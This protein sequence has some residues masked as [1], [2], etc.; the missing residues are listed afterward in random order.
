MELPSIHVWLKEMAI[1]M[2]LIYII[3]EKIAEFENME[4]FAE[5]LKFQNAS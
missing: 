2:K 4:T 5:F 3:W 1:H